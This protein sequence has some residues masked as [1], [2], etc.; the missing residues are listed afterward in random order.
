M[1]SGSGGLIVVVFELEVPLV[2]TRGLE[3]DDSLGDCRVDSIQRE[4]TVLGVDEIKPLRLPGI[5]R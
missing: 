4:R 2:L 3:L 5:P 1:A